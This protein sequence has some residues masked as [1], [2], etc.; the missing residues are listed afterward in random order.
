MS[1]KLRELV[2]QV[3]ACKTA[4]E[5][6]AVI[7]KESALI[8][9]S[10]REEDNSFRHRNVAKL[11]FIHMLGYPTHFGQM[12][13]LKLIAS[14]K[15]PE[16]RI[17]YLGLTQLLDENTEVLM[18]VTNSIKND[19]NHANQYIV[20]LA[21]V[22][23]GDIS[24]AEM[25][26]DLASEVDK[27]LRSANPYIRKKAALTA[28]RVIRKCPDVLELYI[29][30]IGPLL[31]DKNH[32]VMLTGMDL[33]YELMEQS[34]SLID[35]Y[36]RYVPLLV[37]VLKDL[38]KSGYSPEHDI[39]GIIDP[40]LQVRVL[41]LLRVLARGDTAASDDA[42]DI[43]AQV[44]TNTES[45]KNAGNAILYE[46]VNTIMSIESESGLR[47]LAINILG[48]FL[49]NRDNNIRYV[50][51]NT[52]TRVVNADVQ[53]VQRHRQTIVECLKDPDIS[54]RRRALDLTYA[55][56][57]ESNIKSLVKELLNYLL[58]ADIEFKQD[59]TTKICL[60]VEKYA[61]NKRWLVDTIFKVMALAGNYVREDVI[62]SIIQLVSA[63]AEL[64]AYAVTKI[65][66][67]VKE[68][69][70]QESLVQVGVWC[71]GEFGELLVSGQ[72]VD[73]D[74]RPIR[75]SEDEVVDLLDAIVK[76]PSIPQVTKEYCL[77][78]Y[79][80]LLTRF[81]NAGALDRIR[82]SI[83]AFQSSIQ[84]ELQQRACEYSQLMST[85]WDSLRLGILERMPVPEKRTDTFIRDT[86]I[87]DLAVDDAPEK[88]ESASP[89]QPGVKKPASGGSTS[90]P[91]PK[92]D[93][94]LDDL[95]SLDTPVDAPISS[96][97]PV[98]QGP[99]TTDSLLD[100][101]G[102][103]SMTPTPSATA[104]QNKQP[105]DML[106]DL[107]GGPSMSMPA[108]PPPTQPIFGGPAN[109]YGAAP[110]GAAPMGGAAQYPN[111]TAY[112]KDGVNVTF[113]FNKPN[114]ASN[115]VEIVARF[116]NAM[117]VPL[118]NF[119]FQA[120]VPKY[121]K[122]QMLPASST[123]LPPNSKGAVTQVIKLEN[124]LHGE[125]PLLMKLKVDFVNNGQPISEVGQVNSFPAGI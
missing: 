66:Y 18:L 63:T 55:L 88:K 28:I 76:R 93:N 104:P 6:R 68:N 1:V 35:Q 90:A 4:A 48:R 94:L 42:N 116:S 20:G 103:P 54:I 95:L 123:T 13:C 75:I 52:L 61:P 3:R 39:A 44:A 5:E 91:A 79:A 97:A 32:S 102:G 96:P 72:S 73:A 67:S 120:A 9:S 84:T 30:R 10:F 125:K 74:G 106:M 59:L 11:L 101:F 56:V 92:R 38:L 119:V 108:N 7:Q 77:T 85:H 80:K 117:P 41:R 124:T 19:L 26:R 107:L 49:M 31:E 43:L 87:G 78:A 37:R 86:P 40:F 64:H 109:P 69:L 71:I 47:V 118:Q 60:V 12:E 29:D 21:L 34:K 112:E 17:G 22:A 46:C 2:R 14:P 110:F 81:S 83:A 51:L 113:S 105:S 53:A 99:S 25:C 65:F 15:F 89:P 70:G 8:R 23:L 62:A 100:I 122:L 115:Q 50:A 82:T 111:I 24:S 36:R 45:S 58:V 16:K 121:I 98:S 57:N 27:L 114:P 33:L